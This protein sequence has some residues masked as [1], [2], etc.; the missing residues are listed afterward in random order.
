MIA[1]GWGKCSFNCYPLLALKNSKSTCLQEFAPLS[2]PL[3]DSK[4]LDSLYDQF[5]GELKHLSACL[6]PLEN[7]KF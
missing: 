5:Y 7:E 2:N 6:L 1:T 3:S 4:K